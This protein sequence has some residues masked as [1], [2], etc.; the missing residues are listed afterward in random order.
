MTFIAGQSLNGVGEVDIANLDIE[1]ALMAVQS[2]R[3]DLLDQ[4]VRQQLDAVQARNDQMA[5]LNNTLSAKTAENVKLQ[6]ENA[7]L[8][9]Q[10]AQ[11]KDL[12]GRLAASKC[13]D[14]NGWYGLSYGQGD[15]KALVVN[16][17]LDLTPY[18]R[19]DILLALPLHPLCGSDCGGLEF[20]GI[21]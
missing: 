11:M 20:R 15:D 14:P 17:C 6:A 16:D 3:T 21:W 2:R 18:V 12:Q 13:P 1:T 19:E 7:S 10:V 4:S 8:S 9:A 5:E